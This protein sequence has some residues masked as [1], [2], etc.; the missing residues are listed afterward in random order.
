MGRESRVERKA[1]AKVS[2][3]IMKSKG[4]ESQNDGSEEEE[5][6]ECFR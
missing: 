4:S 3:D 2:S 1:L 5:E 6:P